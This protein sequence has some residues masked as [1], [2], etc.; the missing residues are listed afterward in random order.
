MVV[1]LVSEGQVASV[2]R[3]LWQYL[4]AYLQPNYELAHQAGSFPTQAS[5]LML[6]TDDE[7]NPEI[8]FTLRAQHL[9]N[10]P[11]EVAF[12]GGMWE[13]QDVTL[14]ETALRES[15]EEI[16]LPPA[17]V[18]V[19]GACRPRSTR[20]GVRVTPF[21]GV[22]PAETELVPNLSELDAIFRVP[23]ASF[24]SGAIQTRTDIFSHAGQ[25]YRVP[26][27]EHQGYEIW[28][29]TAALTEEIITA[30]VAKS[31]EL[32]LIQ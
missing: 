32:T 21:V 20:A 30:I 23:L 5:V 22:I 16:G 25:S 3:Q 24:H 2:M 29:F 31:S 6:F 1:A 11:G 28:G 17:Q 10:H 7:Q 8:I 9:S 14:L 15:Y 13:P 12:P 26:A 19:L 27:Y 4:Q 18:N